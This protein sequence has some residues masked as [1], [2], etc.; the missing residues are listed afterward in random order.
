MNLEKLEIEKRKIS[1]KCLILYDEE[2]TDE[3]KLK[4]LD[5]I[6]ADFKDYYSK[7]IIIFNDVLNENDRTARIEKLYNIVYFFYPYSAEKYSENEFDKFTPIDYDQL[8]NELRSFFDYFKRGIIILPRLGISA[9]KII[10]IHNPDQLNLNEFFQNVIIDEMRFL[11]NTLFYNQDEL[12]S[13]K[14]NE[15]RSEGS[16]DIEVSY[17]LDEGEDNEDT[18]YNRMVKDFYHN[19]FLNKSN[20]IQIEEYFLKSS[21][22][23]DSK[24]DSLGLNNQHENIEYFPQKIYEQINELLPGDK[25][26]EVIAGIA[27]L[28]SETIKKINEIIESYTEKASEFIHG[29]IVPGSILNKDVIASID[30]ND[31]IKS[32]IKSGGIVYIDEMIQMLHEIDNDYAEEIRKKIF[33]FRDIKYLYDR[34]L[35]KVLREVDNQVLATALKNVDSDIMEKVLKNFSN[36]AGALLKKDIEFI[37]KVHKKDI[38]KARGKISDIVNKLAEAGD[39]HLPNS[40]KSTNY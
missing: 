15:N 2:A 12:D 1:E 3:V 9:K 39:I 30:F 24:I 33:L 4:A 8:L 20:E 21:N 16:P 35:Q 36:R 7:F 28:E 19:A 6:S 22:E 5:E 31:L 40:D 18:L 23:I 29:K 10:M 37:G 13:I 25:K 26:K 27:R 14:K 11:I 38:M 32:L 34:D 17:D